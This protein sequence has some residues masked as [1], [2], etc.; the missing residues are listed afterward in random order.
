M[1]Y[2][3][4]HPFL[5]NPSYIDRR[6]LGTFWKEKY[7]FE[8]RLKAMRSEFNNIRPEYLYESEKS[9]YVYM[10]IPS[11]KRGNTYDVVIHFFTTSDIVKTDYSLRN[12]DIEIFSNNPVF[13]FHFGYANYHAGIIIPFLA[14]KLGRDILTT[15][16]KA[17]N[18]R[19]AMGYDHSFYIAGRILVDSP[20]Y[21]NKTYIKEHAHE[22][23]EDKLIKVVRT[24]EDIQKEY[25][26]NQD[27]DPNKIAFNRDKSLKDRAGETVAD[28]KAKVGEVI[29]RT[30]G[31]GVKRVKPASSVGGQKRI[32]TVKATKSVGTS[33]TRSATKKAI[34]P[35]A[36]KKPKRKI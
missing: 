15:P 6:Q 8:D 25:K 10:K 21:L 1:P 9:Y 35:I 20:R 2:P 28:V 14:N 24:L 13:G 12:Y 33:A 29:D 11:H 22:F 36:K 5:E 34:K 27:D 30:F 31:T 19:N 16:A 23:D 3:K 7:N 32:K 18:P 4:L 17:Y 26:A